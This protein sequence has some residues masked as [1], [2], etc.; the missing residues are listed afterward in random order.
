MQINSMNVGIKAIGT[1]PIKSNKRNE[2]I[3]GQDLVIEGTR[4]KND[5]HLYADR[6]GV[7]IAHRMIR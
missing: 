7:L 2:G 1:C 3:K 4:I 5:D 6:D